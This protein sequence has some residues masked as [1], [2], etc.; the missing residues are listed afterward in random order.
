VIGQTQQDVLDIVQQMVNDYDYYTKQCNN[1]SCD[2]TYIV[3]IKNNTIV[4]C[5]GIKNNIIT[6]LRVK[7]N[8]R[9]EGIG[10]LLINMAENMI[11]KRS[12]SEVFAFVHYN[13]R[14]AFNLFAKNY[15][16]IVNRWKYCY[17]LKK[18]LH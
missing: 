2:T 5:I 12:Y 17:R 10:S 7:K 14:P 1:T 4:G 15:Y 6:H 16:F 9:R 13:N 18:S 11:K 8:S 3:E